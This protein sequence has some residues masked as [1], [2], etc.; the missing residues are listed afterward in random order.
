MPALVMALVANGKML[1][2]QFLPNAMRR[3]RDTNNISHLDFIPDGPGFAPRAA[4]TFSVANLDVKDGTAQKVRVI[5]SGHRAD[6]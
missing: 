2:H 1:Q 5:G 6:P 3:T 4:P